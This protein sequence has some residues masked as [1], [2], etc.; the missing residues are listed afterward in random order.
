MPNKFHCRHA[1]CKW[2]LL[3]VMQQE[4]SRG[5]L[6]LNNTNLRPKPTLSWLFGTASAPFWCAGVL[7]ALTMSR[8]AL[9]SIKQLVMQENAEPHRGRCDEDSEVTYELGVQ[10]QPCCVPTQAQ[11]WIKL[12]SAHPSIQ[13]EYQFGHDHLHNIN[14]ARQKHRKDTQPN[15]INSAV[16][17][18][19]TIT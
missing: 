17:P 15:T 13:P 12:I 7:A 9:G 5:P 11:V 14:P 6:T 16:P 19:C 8:H 18:A 1:I 3:K 2:S 4:N 10:G